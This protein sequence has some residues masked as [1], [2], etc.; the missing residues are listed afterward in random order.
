M[1]KNRWVLYALNIFLLVL[2]GYVIL[3]DYSLNKLNFERTS[4]MLTSVLVEDDH[5]MNKRP[6][7][8][9][10]NNVKQKRL[11]LRL[12][13]S[14]YHEYYISDIYESYWGH[15]QNP[16]VLGKEVVMYLASEDKRQDPFRLEIDG[17]VVFD[18]HIRFYRNT[19]IILFTLALTIYNLYHYFESDIGTAIA[20]LKKNRSHYH[21]D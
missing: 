13:D 5:F 3:P 18:T 16:N 4:G 20:R 17:T 19:L 12:A 1:L 6:K 11:V 8:L 14:D 9:L 2:V 15:I 21:I 10:F 7:R